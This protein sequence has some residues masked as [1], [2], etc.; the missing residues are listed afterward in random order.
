MA[1]E[2][3]YTIQDM[4][5]RCG[6]TVHTLRYY[7]RIGLIQPVGR[8]PTGH[9]RYS[10]ADEAWLKLLHWMRTTDMPIREMLRYAALRDTGHKRAQEQRQIL[11]EHRA[12]LEKEIAKLKEA[13]SRLTRHID[14]LRDVEEAR[15]AA[16]PAAS[17]GQAA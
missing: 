16:P 1:G 9:R 4:A 10:D 15:T 5:A 12:G 8:G 17:T 7:E 2:A 13:L 14:S 3:G 6:M 11:E